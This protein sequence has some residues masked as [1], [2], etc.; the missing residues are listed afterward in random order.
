ML[1]INQICLIILSIAVQRYRI[2]QALKDRWFDTK[3]PRCCRGSLWLLYDNLTSS[4]HQ[5]NNFRSNLVSRSVYITKA[6]HSFW[7]EHLSHCDQSSDRTPHL[8]DAIGSSLHRI[9]PLSTRQQHRFSTLSGLITDHDISSSQGTDALKNCQGQFA[10]QIRYHVIIFDSNNV[11]DALV[12]ERKKWLNFSQS[13][14]WAICRGGCPIEFICDH[15]RI[16]I[17]RYL[18]LKW[19]TDGY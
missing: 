7:V 19:R 10:E 6:L 1:L 4:G 17:C 2:I 16:K 12:F 13:K 5:L 14:A 18:R 9:P 15:W 11:T 8:L 3:Q